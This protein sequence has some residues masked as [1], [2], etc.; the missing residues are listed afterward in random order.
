MFYVTCGGRGS[1]KQRLEEEE[2]E[3][4]TLYFL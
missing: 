2:E 1:N 4:Y 3:E